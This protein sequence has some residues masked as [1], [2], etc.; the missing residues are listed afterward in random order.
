MIIATLMDKART[1]AGIATD[2]A[3]AERL[4]RSRAVVSEWRAG[5][6]YPDEDL[7]I[8]LAKIAGDDPRQWLVAV[9]AVRADGPAKRYWEDISKAIGA[10]TL[11]VLCAIGLAIG[12]TPEALAHKRFAD[13]PAKNEASESDE[14]LLCKSKYRGSGLVGPA[15]ALVTRMEAATVQ[16]LD[17]PMQIPAEP[18]RRQPLQAAGSIRTHLMN[19]SPCTPNTA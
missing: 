11:A 6:S 17:C 15:E 14:C 19:A 9:R 8:T 7:I 1:R 18:R 2:M 4:N 16:V 3:L 13:Q 5:K 12:A 10:A